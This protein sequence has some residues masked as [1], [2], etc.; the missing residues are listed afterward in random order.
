MVVQVDVEFT[1]RSASCFVAACVRLCS[2]GKNLCWLET[3]LQGRRKQRG[4]N[5]APCCPSL[6]LM[7]AVLHTLLSI[8][9]CYTYPLGRTKISQPSYVGTITSSKFVRLSLQPSTI[10]LT[11]PPSTLALLSPLSKSPQIRRLDQSPNPPFNLRTYPSAGSYVGDLV[12][13]ALIA[14]QTALIAGPLAPILRPWF[15][16]KRVMRFLV[17]LTL[18][19]SIVGSTFFPYSPTA[20][21][22]MAV[23]HTIWTQGKEKPLFKFGTTS[24]LQVIEAEGSGTYGKRT[25]NLFCR[26]A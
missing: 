3:A 6:L 5:R 18:L 19:G 4:E 8:C 21:K 20:V 2:A 22:R 9:C 10:C 23:Q 15:A 12:L 13:A 11:N 16:H 26:T 1:E 17:Y 14:F 25:N 24:F 7:N